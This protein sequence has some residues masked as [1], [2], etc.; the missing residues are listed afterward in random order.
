MEATQ[1]ECKNKEAAEVTN[2]NT[3]SSS[4]SWRN[5]SMIANEMIRLF[6]YYFNIP[7]A[8]YLVEGVIISLNLVEYGVLVLLMTYLTSIS[9]Y[10]LVRAVAT[11][12]IFSFISGILAIFAELCALRV[13]CYFMVQVNSISYILGLVVLLTNIKHPGSF[14]A[15][16]GALFLL[17]VGHGILLS[18]CKEEFMKDQMKKAS[19]VPNED[20]EKRD[21]IRA[22]IS[23]MRTKVVG[24]GLSNLLVNKKTWRDQILISISIL[25]CTTF[26]LFAWKVIPIISSTSC[27]S[28]QSPKDEDG[29]KEI[30]L[31]SK[32]LQSQENEDDHSEYHPKEEN[33]ET[34][35]SSNQQSTSLRSAAPI[36][37]TF[38]VY[39]IVCST[40]DTFFQDQAGSVDTS[41]MGGDY[42][43]VMMLQIITRTSRYVI[44]HF[45]CYVLSKRTRTGTLAILIRMGLGMFFTIVTC[46]VAQWTEVVRLTAIKNN[47]TF[48]VSP[49]DE[50]A[51]P[52]IPVVLFIPQY[53]ALGFVTGL[54]GEGLEVFFQSEYSGWIKYCATAIT[55]ALTGIG[56]LLT[57]VLVFTQ[58]MS[59]IDLFYRCVAFMCVFNF[60]PL[61]S[62][63]ST[64]YYRKIKIWRLLKDGM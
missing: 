12:N 62:L 23:T 24:F 25:S 6:L 52:D 17:A 4:S 57:M 3:S 2:D 13:G 34:A 8:C 50:I 29:N 39:G 22:T 30:A 55:E 45:V 5:P 31:S 54:A 38:L 49:D 18:T 56:S 16:H 43:S 15:L 1:V 41:S 14:Q 47:N 7:K 20:D 48:K 32:R 10:S 36:C 33:M 51:R 28:S 61:Y 59:R 27:S 46:T 21:E 9:G 42:M 37:F 60:I 19:R 44:N 58:D 53:I 11:V 63:A 35:L 40:G 26:C 64:S